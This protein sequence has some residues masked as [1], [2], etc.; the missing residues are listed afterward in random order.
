MGAKSQ[1]ILTMVAGIGCTG[2]MVALLKRYGT[3]S[4]KRSYR[5]VPWAVRTSEDST[6]HARCG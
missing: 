5:F 2:A 1:T 3:S 4:I 6:L